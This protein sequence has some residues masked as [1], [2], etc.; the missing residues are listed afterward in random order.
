[1]TAKIIWIVVAAL[2]TVGAMIWFGKVVAK[3]ELPEEKNPQ[4]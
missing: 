1:M 3:E 2:A 4:G